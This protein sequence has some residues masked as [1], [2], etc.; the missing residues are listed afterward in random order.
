MYVVVS[1]ISI[2]ADK[3][4]CYS[5][6]DLSALSILGKLHWINRDKLITFILDAQVR[7]DTE[8]SQLSY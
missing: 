4:V 5:W 1:E 3:Q 8:L 6:W 2:R 7:I